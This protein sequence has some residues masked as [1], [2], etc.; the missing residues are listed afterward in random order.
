MASGE[1]GALATSFSA[2]VRARSNSATRRAAAM[3]PARACFNWSGG[4]IVSAR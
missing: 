4:T 2:S 3:T 1:V